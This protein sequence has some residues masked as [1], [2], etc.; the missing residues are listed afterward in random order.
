MADGLCLLPTELLVDLLLK[1]LTGAE[2]LNL[3]FSSK[4]WARRLRNQEYLWQELYWRRNG[5][6]PP[7]SYVGTLQDLYLRSV[8][9]EKLV[10]VAQGLNPPMSLLLSQNTSLFAMKKKVRFAQQQ[11]QP[12]GES[13]E[14]FELVVGQTGEVVGVW[15]NDFAPNNDK[16]DAVFAF[17]QR[18]GVAHLLPEQLRRGGSAP[19][20]HCPTARG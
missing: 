14:D 17:A 20:P 9:G 19:L 16:M 15:G 10:L 12:N 18:L 13:F 6:L 2:A 1:F 5:V 3:V 4:A 7:L 11:Q 8:R